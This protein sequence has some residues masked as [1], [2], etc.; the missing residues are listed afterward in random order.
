MACLAIGTYASPQADEVLRA[1]LPGLTGAA[2]AQVITTLGDRR[3]Q[4]AIPALGDLARGADGVAAEAA[5]VA[6]GK[7]ASEPALG[8]LAALRR[9][10]NPALASAVLE[11]TLH[12]ADRLAAN[13][14]GPAAASLYEELLAAGQPIHARRGALSALLRL[15]GEAG[16]ARI[17]KV[18]HGNDAALRPVAIAAVSVLRS[19]GASGVFAAELPK[20]AV[21]EQVWLIEALAS[22]GDPA[23]RSAVTAQL[24]AAEGAVR[25]AA[26]QALGRTG[27]A[28]SASALAKALGR[29]ASPGETLQLSQALV[30]LEGGDAT[31]RAVLTELKKAAP[32]AKARLISALGLR[33]SRIATSAILAEASGEHA[34]VVTA[35]F[36]ALARVGR[37]QDL[38]PVL[39]ALARLRV[40]AARPEAEAGAIQVLGREPEAARRSEVLCAQLA[41]ALGVEARCSL[42]RL[43]PSAGGSKAF[44]A[45][46][47]ACAEGDERIRDAAGRALVE[48]PDLTAWPKLLAAYRQPPNEAQRVLALR[49]LVRLASEA[50]AQP[51]AALAARYR[52]LLE[53]AKNDNDRKLILG[54]LGGAAQP[55]ALDL[56]A[57][58]LENA[59]VRAEARLAIQKIAEAIK[60]K[61]P[62]AAQAAL[63]KVKAAP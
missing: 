46:T 22:R 41:R 17:L 1:A 20:L 19:K 12:A 57:P 11:A 21:P 28:A 5:I 53:G 40:N 3:D 47:A 50:N 18:L 56:A 27:G 10:T 8:S 16:Q 62:Q 38:P 7:I 33:G 4:A 45:L 30:A 13:G 36:Q 31:D 49:G 52:E 37:A 60:E 34:T 63:E 55:E 9:E 14:N 59:G 32:D 24:S 15:E 6:L 39:E 35:A 29:A 26:A 25:I 48:W 51:G 61:H 42:I 44:E 58:L 43:L 2:R 23:A 54:A